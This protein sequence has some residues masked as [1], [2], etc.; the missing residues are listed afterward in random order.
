MLTDKQRAGIR[1]FLGSEDRHRQRGSD[2]LNEA[3]AYLVHTRDPRYFL[4]GR[5]GMTDAE[6]TML[7]ETFVRGMPDSWLNTPIQADA[8]K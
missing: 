2:L 3:Q 8:A 4:P 5:V 6:A 1:H 7:R